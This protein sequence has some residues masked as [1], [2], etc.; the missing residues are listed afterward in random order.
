[1]Q[2]GRALTG[3]IAALVSLTVCFALTA[4]IAWLA[5]RVGLLQTAIA[6]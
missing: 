1:M 5:P 6:V 2:R 3:L 4:S